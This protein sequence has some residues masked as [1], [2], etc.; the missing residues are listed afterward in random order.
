MFDE[1]IN[2]QNHI[3]IINY[4]LLPTKRCCAFF[5]IRNIIQYNILGVRTE[6]HKN[7]Y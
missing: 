1:N 6:I 4:I 2:R 5:G 3:N 7:I